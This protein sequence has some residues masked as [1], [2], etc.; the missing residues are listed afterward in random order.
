MV[1]FISAP[2]DLLFSTA[3]S[4]AKWR[5]SLHRVQKTRQRQLCHRTLKSSSS[6]INHTGLEENTSLGQV[7]KIEAV[8]GLSLAWDFRILRINI[9]FLGQILALREQF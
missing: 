4:T 9:E 1:Q 5:H 2:D 7:T 8:L 3:L 6:S